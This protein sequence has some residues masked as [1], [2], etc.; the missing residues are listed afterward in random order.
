MPDGIASREGATCLHVGS[1]LH[2]TTEVQTK[3]MGLNKNWVKF[4]LKSQQKSLLHRSKNPKSVQ[5]IHWMEA[6]E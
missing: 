4:Y 5:S 2:H 6:L 1:P 3:K